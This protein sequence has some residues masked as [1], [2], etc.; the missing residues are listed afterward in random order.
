MGHAAEADEFLELLGDELGAVVA[1]HPRI[2]AGELL[3]C[4]LDDDL[5]L[6]LLE[7][8]ADFPMDDEAAVAVD[9]RAE[10][11]KRAADVQV[12]DVDVPMLVGTRRLRESLPF[13]RRLAGKT[14]H[15]P[16]RLE[17]AV[18]GSRAGGHHVPV[19][20]HER[21]AAVALQRILPLEVE[22][23]LFLPLLQ[24]PVPR[25]PSVVL[26]E[27]AVAILPVVELALAD[28]DPAHQRLGA[29]LGAITPAAHVVDDFVPRVVG[30]PASSQG[31][32]MAFFSSTCSCISSAITSLKE[33]ATPEPQL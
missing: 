24:P 25:H 29:Q 22:D 10:V 4:P 33:N 12:R 5:R 2:L 23:G 19:Q 15:P 21:H 17:H 8:F 18:D 20:H 26:V 6:A 11:V 16:R 30:N 28:A 3:P 27:L 1:N 14:P 13:L 31:S 9:N 32:P 7:R